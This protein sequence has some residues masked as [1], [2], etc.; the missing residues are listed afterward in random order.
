MHY[1]VSLRLFSLFAGVGLVLGSAGFLKA[2]Q[3]IEKK[4]LEKLERDFESS[5]RKLNS[6]DAAAN[7]KDKN[8]AEA[9]AKW[10]IYRIAVPGFDMAKVHKEFEYNMGTTL[11]AKLKNK[12]KVY[13][14]LY[15][16]ALATALGHVLE[17]NPVQSQ[18]TTAVNAAMMLSTMAKLKHKATS[19]LLIK[20]IQDEKDVHDAI[21]LYAFRAMR[22]AMPIRIQLDPAHAI[23]PEEFTNAAQNAQRALDAQNVDT[24]TKFIERPATITGMTQQQIDAVRY[25][26]RE[27]IIAL[28]Q[29]GAPAVNALAENKPQKRPEVTKAFVAPTLMKVLVKG[30]LRPEPSI[31]EKIE[32]ALGLCAMKYPNMPEYNAHLGVYL[33]GTAVLDFANEYN[34]DHTNF[35]VTGPTKKLPY[36]QFKGEAIRLKAGLAELIKNMPKDPV[37]VTN[38]RDPEA[39]KAADMLDAKYQYLHDRIAT[40][41]GF[42]PAS[43]E[44]T[45]LGLEL[46]KMR[47]KSSAVFKTLK[48]SP[49]LQIDGN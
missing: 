42:L 44:A 27:A 46:P 35:S 33:V 1:R 43:N 9:Q 3:P 4:E 49:I 6:G 14:D 23:N 8:V 48:N 2:Q 39:K 47:P 15:A 40:L 20:L 36:L 31:Q 16:P 45:A 34:K 21:R 5:W 30:Q 29:S 24:L 18:P 26:R 41:K 12:N 38:Y 22:E 10:F 28:A 17:I 7:A 32:A 13:L 19:D 11:E 25:I 37:N